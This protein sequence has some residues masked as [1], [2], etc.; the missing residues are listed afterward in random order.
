MAHELGHLV[1]HTGLGLARMASSGDI[2]PYRSSE[3]QANALA[4]ELL[5]S[6]EHIGN[7]HSALE[8]ALKFGVTTEA[9]N[10]QWNAFR[11]EGLVR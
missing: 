3:W 8:A 11:K 5:V 2:K 10:I 6:Y 7:C 4:G 9:A 1:L